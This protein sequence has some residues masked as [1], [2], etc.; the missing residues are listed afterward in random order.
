MLLTKG[1]SIEIFYSLHFGLL[2]STDFPL[3]RCRHVAGSWESPGL[4][5]NCREDLLLQVYKIPHHLTLC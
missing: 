1:A 4:L 5:I 2:E 3:M